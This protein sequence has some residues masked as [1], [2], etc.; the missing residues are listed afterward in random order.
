[1]RRRRG[2]R[3]AGSVPSVPR[4]LC[5]C[6]GSSAPRTR[7]GSDS[8]SR[9]LQRPGRACHAYGK[10]PSMAELAGVLCDWGCAGLRTWPYDRTPRGVHLSLAGKGIASPRTVLG[11]TASVPDTLLFRALSSGRLLFRGAG[12]E[13]PSPVGVRQPRERQHNEQE[14][15]CYIGPE[16]LAIDEDDCDADAQ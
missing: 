8:R 15:A 11:A 4:P 13:R 2:P 9:V 3:L 14:C 5:L 12:M 16:V 10:E 6:N 7:S 1:M